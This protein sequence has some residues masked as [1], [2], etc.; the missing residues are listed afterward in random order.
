MKRLMKTLAPVVSLAVV[1]MAPLALAGSTSDSIFCFKATDG[2]GF[3]SGNF[4]G[5]RNS[6][7]STEYV[8]FSENDSGTRS[9]YA[10]YV[11]AGSTSPTTF[12]CTPDT[13]VTAMWRE[14]LA[15]KGYF[16]VSWDELGN[17]FNLVLSNG[18]QY[19]HF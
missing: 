10:R 15:H 6:A 9:F 5:W 19:S 13:S 1:G 14:A 7:T 12:T 4:L 11:V 3:C 18:S 16:S 2:S 17:C 8:Y